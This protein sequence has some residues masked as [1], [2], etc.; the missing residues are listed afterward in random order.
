MAQR[1]FYNVLGV[2]RDASAA[3]IKSAYRK[4]ARQYHPDVNKAS[5]A[6]EKFRE[7]SEA[8]DV[9]S[10]AEKRQRYDQFGHAGVGGGP[11]GA[12]C[13]GCGGMGV[14]FSQFFSG[15]GGF[16]MSLDELLQNLGGG[17]A[18]RKS[19]RRG[20]AARGA[21]LEYPV[22]LDFLQAAHGVTTTI[23]VR[24]DQGPK[25][26]QEEVIETKIPAGVA[27]GQKIRLRGKGQPGAQA[28]GDLFIVVSV[29]RHPTF[30]R[31]GNDV[32]V[33]VPIS[34]TEAAL[35]AKVDVPT[36][37]GMTTVTIPPGTSSGQKLRLRGKGIAG[38]P[39]RGEQYVVIKI[40]A[41]D[42]LSDQQRTLLEQLRDAEPD[43]VRAN[44][45][46]RK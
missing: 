5:D 41:P 2:P 18:A 40:V 46:W 32:I 26:G 27:D 45:P 17:R 9:L 30:R 44:A 43:D 31:E 22:T 4:L 24:R 20:P 1:D 7:A 25:A 3:Q 39:S 10:D 38:G 12:G 11:Q 16:G 37:D 42:A 6:A 28:P 36:I 23:R 8:Y 13:G 33:D 15:N 21:D 19:R 34:L 35:G 29:Q 14:D